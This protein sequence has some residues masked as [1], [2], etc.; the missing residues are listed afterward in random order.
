MTFL[1]VFVILSS[2]LIVSCK[3]TRQR[4][5]VSADKRKVSA[6]DNRKN[7]H[8]ELE[9]SIVIQKEKVATL[10]TQLAGLEQQSDA[11]ETTEQE[12]VEA[13][14]KLAEQE[15][16]LEDSK[17]NNVSSQTWQFYEMLQLESDNKGE[18]ER[19]KLCLESFTAEDGTFSS[20]F[21]YCSDSLLYLPQ[22]YRLRN[23]ASSDAFVNEA[24]G[25]CLTAVKDSPDSGYT[26]LRQK[27]CDNST[28]QNFSFHNVDLEKRLVLP[29]Q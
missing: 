22:Q 28:E 14:E 4:V 29:A 20:Q 6:L 19:E 9:S 27:T 23:F 10:E 16:E 13:R 8:K 21:E 25:L 12:L 18:N 5:E 11:A 7:G 2:F 3:T 24:S 26:A 15:D 17:K 1:R